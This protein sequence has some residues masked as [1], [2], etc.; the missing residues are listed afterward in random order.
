MNWITLQQ[1]HSQYDWKNLLSHAM[2][3]GDFLWKAPLLLYTHALHPLARVQRYIYEK[4]RQNG[5]IYFGIDNIPL[6]IYCIS[7][8]SLSVELFLEILFAKK[9]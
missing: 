1:R 5:L 6:L 3:G 7:K 4:G 2:K 8:I 9:M